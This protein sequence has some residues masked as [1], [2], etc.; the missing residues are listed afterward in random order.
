MEKWKAIAG[1]LKNWMPD[2]LA[3]AGAVCIST[4]SYLLNPILGIAVIGVSCISAA[5]VI[6]KGGEDG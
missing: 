5:I 2:I 4:A 1:I 3:T 6:S